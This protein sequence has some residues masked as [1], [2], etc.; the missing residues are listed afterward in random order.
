MRCGHGPRHFFWQQVLSW[1]M[2]VQVVVIAGAI[3]LAFR[4]IWS[5]N[6]WIAR[7]EKQ[8]S[9]PS[10]LQ[11]ELPQLEVF[12]RVIRSF[13]VFIFIGI[14]YGIAG[15]YHWARE[16]LHTAGII[17]IFLTLVRLFTESMA[18]RFWA[19]ILAGALYL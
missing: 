6:A 1:A 5:L 4:A 10:E 16:G 3:L 15:H 17:A 7:L 9:L 18:N 11:V 12:K 14:A 13:L 8:P 19:R 2:A